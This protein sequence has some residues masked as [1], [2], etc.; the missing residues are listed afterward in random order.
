MDKGTSNALKVVIVLATA[1]IL[2]VGGAA[3]GYKYYTNMKQQ[4]KPPVNVSP[5]EEQV[6]VKEGQVPEKQIEEKDT[7]KRDTEKEPVEEGIQK[8]Q[9][10]PDFSL[11]DLQGNDISLSDY[12]GKIVF[13]NFWATWC[14]PCK[15][16]MPHFEAANK[17]FQEDNNAVIL[18]VNIQESSEKVEDFIQENG[19]TFPVVL[20]L[21]GQIANQYRIHS[22][23][24]TFI[25]NQ[26][27]VIRDIAIGVMEE[28]ELYHYV[29]ELDS[30]QGDNK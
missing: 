16:E 14:P 12:R 20:D 24:T 25:L 3:F 2:I 23:P 6:P 11:K 8:L 1:L 5:K 21:K 27:G 18:A 17:K 30:E 13:L 4:D 22:I 7:E 10:A 28:E 15:V 19:Y 29:E 26:Q 9:E